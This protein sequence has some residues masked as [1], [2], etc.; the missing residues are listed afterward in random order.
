[1]QTLKGN[2]IRMAE[3]MAALFDRLEVA[4]LAAMTRLAS[5]E[6]AAYTLITDK[7]DIGDCVPYFPAMYANAARAISKFTREAPPSKQVVAF[8]RP[9]ELRALIELVKIKQASLE[10][11]LIVSFECAG[12]FPFQKISLS[13]EKKLRAYGDAVAR[14]ENCEGIRPVCAAC[15]RFIPEG[16]DIVISLIGRSFDDTL[17]LS[18]PSGKGKTAAKVLALDSSSK[19][20]GSFAV[21]NL[22]EKRTKAQS[23][24]S[25]E[26][27]KTLSGIDGLVSVFDKCISCHACSYVCPLCYCKNCYFDSQ[28]FEYFPESLSVRL[29]EKGALRFPVDRLLFHLG[30]LSHMGVSCVACGMCED[31]CPVSIPV[32]RV[33]KTVGAKA[34]TL[35]NY[36]PGKDLGQPMPLVAYARSELEEFEN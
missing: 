24:L 28:T 5:G 26:M 35:F 12:V 29:G 8:L 17:V 3:F 4:G 13:D 25:K 27:E 16:A 7:S 11:L 22:T 18:F 19:I 21:Q 9:C 32:S 33:F 36:V 20:D 6:K 10:N 14:G 15:T 30:R 2:S 23:E 34:Q 31:A 1:M